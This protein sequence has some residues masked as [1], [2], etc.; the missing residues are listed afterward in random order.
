MQ[1]RSRFLTALGS[2]LLVGCIC[3]WC[4]R[5]GH[6]PLDAGTLTASN[7]LIIEGLPAISLS[8]VQQASPYLDSRY[9]RLL[10]WD[11][12]RREILISTR[13]AQSSQIHRVAMPGGARTQLTFY[14]DPV[15][16]AIW[17]PKQGKYFLFAK[18]SGGGE[19]YQF[20]RMDEPSGEVTLLT[21]GESRNT[22]PVFAHD[23]SRVAYSFN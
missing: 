11:P 6:G 4:C 10:S 20:Y 12:K 14:G 2:G 13:F 22:G 3:F 15:R 17:Q 1:V 21:D 23:G 7:N 5:P 9:G 8:L 16:T 19:F 18:D